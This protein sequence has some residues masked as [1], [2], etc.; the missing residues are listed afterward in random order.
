VCESLR[1]LVEHPKRTLRPRVGQHPAYAQAVLE[2]RGHRAP[3]GK[4]LR[5]PPE[6]SAESTG[7]RLGWPLPSSRRDC[8]RLL[9]HRWAIQA[10]SS[11]FRRTLGGPSAGGHRRGRAP[12]WSLFW[13]IGGYPLRPDDS[14]RLTESGEP[15][16]RV[17]LRATR[18]AERDTRESGVNPRPW[19]SR[20]K[21]SWVA[22]GSLQAPRDP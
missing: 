5:C 1:L 18:R 16:A 15:L 11:Q 20:R 7:G 9:S 17:F 4:P 2:H 6:D 14:C 3:H 19:V 21:G 12:I 10:Y 22:S 13:S 8:N